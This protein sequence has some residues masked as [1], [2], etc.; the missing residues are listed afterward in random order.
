MDVTSHTG[1]A[2]AGHSRACSAPREGRGRNGEHAGGDR[3]STTKPS[4]TRARSTAPSRSSTASR[5]AFISA[6]AAPRKSSNVATLAQPR[7]GYVTV[8]HLFFRQVAT[9]ARDP[10]SSRPDLQRVLPAEPR[11]RP[12]R[13]GQRRSARCSQRRAHRHL[14]HAPD[15]VTETFTLLRR[16][17]PRARCRSSVARGLP[18][19]QAAVHAR[20]ADRA[21]IKRRDGVIGLIMAQHQLNDGSGRRSR[22][23]PSHSR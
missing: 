10:I 4:S 16:A 1:G 14:A 13:S 17:R 18:L 9:N 21:E 20:R 11:H 8:A 2:R 3:W 12:D 6:T 15:A 22:D 19:R 23:C 5:A 7:R